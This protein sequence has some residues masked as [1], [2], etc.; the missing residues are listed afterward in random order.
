MIVRS[1]VLLI[2]EFFLRSFLVFFVHF[3]QPSYINSFSFVL[4]V[5]AHLTVL[6]FLPALLVL[7]ALLY[8]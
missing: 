2:L 8:R 5:S 1:E 4:W 7:P 3:L 6:S